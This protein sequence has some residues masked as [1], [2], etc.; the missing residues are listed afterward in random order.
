MHSITA[1]RVKIRTDYQFQSNLVS[2]VG[3][4]PPLAYVNAGHYLT[5]QTVDG[6]SRTVLRW[7]QGSGLMLQPSGGVFS[8]NNY[9]VVLLFKL[10]T[11]GGYRRLF[12][13]KNGSSE[14]G[15]Y[16]HDSKL[17]YFGSTSDSAV[18]VTNN[19]WHQAVLTRNA[20]NNQ[21]AIYCDG[22][23]RL[24]FTDSGNNAVI[25]ANNVRFFKDNT[26]EDAA[27]WVARIRNFA[28]AL[29]PGE[30][31][32]LDRLPG[33]SP[34]GN[35]FLLS[36]AHQAAN[37]AFVFQVT[38]PNE[39]VRIESSTNLADWSVVTNLN[40]FAGSYWHTNVLAPGGRFF[41]TRKL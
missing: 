24:S 10:E 19:T 20:A 1:R 36:A 7:P 41:R 11:V 29:T 34:G 35:P 27:G 8:S 37:G 12:D 3:N 33:V 13:A 16:V 22:V 26:S 30:V 4:P 25:S 5:N 23:Q 2:S 39:P 21:V 14:A 18:C 28:T 32:N 17:S 40:S 6:V 31:A 9:T 38:G 15:L